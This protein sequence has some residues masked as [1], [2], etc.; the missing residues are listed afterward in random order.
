MICWVLS[1]EIC[2]TYIYH[3]VALV[4]CA[5]LQECPTCW[6]LKVKHG[7]KAYFKVKGGVTKCV[8]PASGWSAAEMGTQAVDTVLYCLC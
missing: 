1:Q 5:L 4:L 6:L 7:V 3:F 8:N 2:L